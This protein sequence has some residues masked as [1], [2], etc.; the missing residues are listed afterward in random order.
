MTV[1]QTAT[2][3]TW[4]VVW[5]AIRFRPWQYLFNH[6]AALGMG[7]GW[8]VP[9]LVTRHFFNLVTDEAAAAF[10]FWTLMALLATGA[11]GRIGAIFGMIRTNIPF[12][13]HTHALLHKNMLGRILERPGARALPESPGE[14]ISRFRGDVNE[15]PLFGLWLND[16]LGHSIFVLVAI[17]IMLAINARL[18]LITL[19][20][21]FFIVII[22]NAASS[23]IH[24][25]RMAFRKISGIV[26]GFIAE[27]FNAVQ[28]I[29]V[30]RAEENVVDQFAVLNE[31]R[32]EAALRDRL[33]NELLRSIF[34][35]SN[36]LAIA[37]IL[38]AGAGALQAGDFTVG[39][40]ALFV[41]Y[42]HT[43]ANTLAFVGFV[44]ARYKQADVAVERMVR[45]LQ[46]APPARLIEPG[47]VYMDGPLPAVPYPE[48]QAG[49]ILQEL[50]VT[51]LT[52]H[53]PD[54][55]RGIE[56]I[57]LR[58]RRGDFVVITGRIG[59]GKTTLLRA[60]LG[61]LP[62]EKGEI[63]WNGRLVTDP[64][65]FFV[66]PRSAYT[67]QVPRLFSDTLRQNL[68]L[69]L[70]EERVDLAAAIH[71]AVLEDDLREL[72]KGLDTMIG[73]KGVKLSGGQVQRAAT[74]RMF[75]RNAELLVFDDLSSALDVETERTL[76]QRLFTD[77]ARWEAQ[78][79]C[80]VV[81]HRRA[82]LRRADQI[83]VLVNGRVA[84]SGSL[85]QLLETS[86]E[87]QRLWEDKCSCRNSSNRQKAWPRQTS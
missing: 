84:A 63:W 65:S 68:L 8:L 81:S 49:D 82:A 9:G 39:D 3:P 15:M 38:L 78:A 87:M 34:H 37:I 14:A 1:N 75:A 27:T 11:L 60:L 21:L 41:A 16:L 46:G 80:L 13:F 18:A 12:Q 58:L 71:A 62:R 25:Y 83:V 29:Q 85:D 51:G 70:P 53:H 42:M 4:K 17:P 5:G 79:T 73:P 6:I 24:A 43:V 72:E 61:L 20:P 23:R 69:G 54:S 74:A 19:I 7:L 31:R 40:F 86:P 10:G 64:A 47:E 56:G 35:N 45:L 77:E 55:G 44:W 26:V 2:I 59:A 76:W 50:V 32:R 57:N 66:P 67:A 22:A 28:A 36:N 33:F 48:K 30:A 52:Y